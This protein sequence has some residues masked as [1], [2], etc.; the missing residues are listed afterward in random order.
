M[1]G[2]DGDDSGNRLRQWISRVISST[3]LSPYSI[4]IPG[5]AEWVMTGSQWSPD[6]GMM[7]VQEADG[8]DGRGVASVKVTR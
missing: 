1:M 3:L 4:L 6:G 8:H 7:V 5:L 2:R